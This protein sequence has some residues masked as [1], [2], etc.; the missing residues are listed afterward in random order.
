M[1]HAYMHEHDGYIYN[2]MFMCLAWVVGH[3][4][5]EL[6]VVGSIPR[7]EVY[8][9]FNKRPPDSSRVVLGKNP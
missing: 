8:N 4:G 3:W 9:F 1:M 7:I 5:G 6:P 2:Y